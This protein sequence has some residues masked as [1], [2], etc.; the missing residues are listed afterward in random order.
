M[1]ENT[2]RVFAVT[3]VR[4]QPCKSHQERL[5][6]MLWAAP[7]ATFGVFGGLLCSSVRSLSVIKPHCSYK[8]HEEEQPGDPASSGRESSNSRMNP[9][10]FFQRRLHK[11]LHLTQAQGLYLSWLFW[12][13]LGFTSPT[14]LPAGARL[15]RANT[16]EGEELRQSRKAFCWYCLC[17]N[18]GRFPSMHSFFVHTGLQ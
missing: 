17:A 2:N 12:A 18:L 4:T 6:R 3:K 15:H 1:F 9:G 10:I 14:N 11:H 5:E 7:S 13:G 8:A 16:W